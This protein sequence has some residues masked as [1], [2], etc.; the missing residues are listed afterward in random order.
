MLDKTLEQANTA[1]HA[2]FVLDN[3]LQLQ[4]DLVEAEP[5]SKAA[6]MVA[7]HM[8][9]IEA[10]LI[11]QA[12]DTDEAYCNLHDLLS[13]RDRLDSE[14]GQLEKASST[15]HELVQMKDELL[16]EIPAVAAEPNGNSFSLFSAIK[17][18]IANSDLLVP[19]SLDE[20][21][22]FAQQML[23]PRNESSVAELPGVDQPATR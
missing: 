4:D 23:T 5:Q 14:S 3:M 1:R 16:L 17:D 18:A 21:K 8:M 9:M 22:G 2:D 7:N 12:G 13:I 11:A 15:L 20:L 6:Q 10:D 19:V